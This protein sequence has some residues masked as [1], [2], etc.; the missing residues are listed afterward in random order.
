MTSI[1]TSNNCRGRQ[2]S[3]SR[4]D[5]WRRICTCNISPGDH[6]IAPDS[7]C[8]HV[9]WKL[10]LMMKAKQKSDGFILYATVNGTGIAYYLV[11]SH[12]GYTMIIVIVIVFVSTYF[13]ICF[14]HPATPRLVLLHPIEKRYY[15][16]LRSSTTHWRCTFTTWYL[17]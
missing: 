8:E 10:L 13:G 7:L 17:W 12:T 1:K 5:N 11:K 4:R 9:K 16:I 15:I 14:Y 3:K 2:L 6:L